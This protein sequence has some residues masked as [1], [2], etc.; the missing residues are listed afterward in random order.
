MADVQR[1]AK[2]HM[3]RQESIPAEHMKSAKLPRFKSRE[4]EASF[5]ESHDVTEFGEVGEEVKLKFAQPLSVTYSFE[6]DANTLSA[7]VRLAKTQGIA[8]SQLIVLWIKQGLKDARD[9]H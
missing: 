3:R 8:P 9:S 7:I 1:R 2:S 4:E 5:W 6:T